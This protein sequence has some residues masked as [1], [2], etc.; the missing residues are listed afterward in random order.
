MVRKGSMTIFLTLMLS[1]MLTLICSSLLSVRMAAART[2]ILCGM[3]VGLFSL[4][5]QYDR[6][7]LKDFDLFMIDG[8]CGGGTLKMTEIYEN[9]ESYI[10]PVLEQN[11]QNL[12][13]DSGRITGYRL[14]TDQSGEVFYH[15]I[16]EYMKETLGSQGVQLLIDKIM[17][18][19]NQTEAARQR[20]TELNNGTALNSYESEMNQATANS[21]ALEDARK[22]EGTS[23]EIAVIPPKKVVNPITII[24]KIMKMGLLELLVPGGD[25]VS[26]L[27]VDKKTL[28]S[29][30]SLQKGY[31]YTENVNADG[32]L[33]SQILYQIY[34]M[35]RLG[36]YHKPAPKGLAYQMEYIVA[37]KNND[38]DNLLSVAEQLLVIREGVNVAA[39]MA[40]PVKR[41]E[42]EA[43]SL[44]IAASFLV[45]PASVVIEAA[46]VLCWAFAESVLDV[47]E[48][49]AGGRVPLMKN[50]VQ[51]QL[52]LENLPYL[53]DLLD[54]SR[55]N[56]AGGLSYQ[57]Y[58][59]LLVLSRTR[60]TKVTR[61]MDMVEVQIRNNTGRDSFRL[62]SGIVAV[63][64]YMEVYTN[65]RKTYK[66]TRQY[67]YD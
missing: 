4:F 32:S 50:G 45:P 43:L 12:A 9:L 16:V 26:T 10:T 20:G 63:E 18:N 49:F 14:L 15:Q 39:L 34:L 61:G 25:K 5:G 62:D 55:R 51:W 7:V 40:D 57:D 42:V 33:T 66:V 8:S 13:L 24:R 21:K 17:E 27:K 3:D 31:N 65:R 22:Q 44:A 37:G 59:H 11:H 19:K 23:T 28:V 48:L 67:S 52:S 47:R 56:T 2:Q 41:A 30:R 46:L 6:Q 29:G 64:A 60:S 36:N 35:N 53:M 54:V 1:L 38:R 58:L